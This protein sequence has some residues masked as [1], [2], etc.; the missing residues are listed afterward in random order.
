LWELTVLEKHYYPAV[1]TMASS[2]GRMETKQA[3]M[4]DMEDFLVHTYKSL[5]D[6][7]RKRLEKK[8]KKVPLAFVKPT[9]LFVETDVFA[10]MLQLGGEA[11]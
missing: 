4:H 7:E 5:F 8:R 3:P 1:A 2:L 6:Q 9:S 11:K 10:G